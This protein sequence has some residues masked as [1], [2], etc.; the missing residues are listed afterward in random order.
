M[1]TQ[2]AN[3]L[4]I[5]C[6][7][8]KVPALVTMIRGSKSNCKV[9][10]IDNLPAEIKQYDAIIISG[11]PIL[12]TETE[13]KIYLEK[14][15]PVFNSS[16]P[17]LGICFGHQCMGLHF[18]AKIS[19]GIEDRSHTLITK[20]NDCELLIGLNDEFEMSEDHCEEINVPEEFLLI[21]SSKNCK[22]EFMQHRNKLFF[23]VQFHPETSGE[24]GKKIIL[25]FIHLSKKQK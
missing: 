21:A 11:A 16:K 4:L 23:G 22:N 12:L 6:G 15:K 2:T 7:S 20:I 24:N 8:T 18:A 9:A 10:T 25:N 19:K 17:V 3:I 1:R 13:P 14:L 5:D